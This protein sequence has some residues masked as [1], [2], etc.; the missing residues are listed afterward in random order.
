MRIYIVADV[1][2]LRP[3][4]ANTELCCRMFVKKSFESDVPPRRG[5]AVAPVDLEVK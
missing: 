4:L 2:V 5:I 1:P 3:G